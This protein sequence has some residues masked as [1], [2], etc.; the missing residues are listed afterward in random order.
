[1]AV[2]V[3]V[4][5]DVDSH[6]RIACTPHSLLVQGV[7]HTLHRCIGL[8]GILHVLERAWRGRALLRSC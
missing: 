5:L 2:L 7:T 8:T 3:E 1:M 6:Q 4:A